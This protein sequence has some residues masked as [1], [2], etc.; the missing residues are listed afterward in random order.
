MNETAVFCSVWQYR[1]YNKRYV[2]FSPQTL[3]T[4]DLA[5][6]NN[7]KKANEKRQ[8]I[9]KWLHFIIIGTGTPFLLAAI[10]MMLILNIIVIEFSNARKSIRFLCFFTNSMMRLDLLYWR[11]APFWV[12][13]CTNFTNFLVGLN[14]NT[15]FWWEN[16]F[17]EK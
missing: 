2:F 5:C 15:Y 13:L 10:S 14:R 7:T 1:S 3:S 4:R 12:S 16:S 8:W 9:L 17:A 6:I 11:N